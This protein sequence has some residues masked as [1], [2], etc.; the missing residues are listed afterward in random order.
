MN[1]PTRQKHEMKISLEVISDPLVRN[2]L[3]VIFPQSSS[4]RFDQ[5]MLI[6][7]ASDHF[8]SKKITKKNGLHFA[9]FRHTPVSYKKAHLLLQICCSWNG[10]ICFFNGLPKS[11]WKMLL[12]MECYLTAIQCDDPRAHCYTDA[13][14]VG[15]D[16][17]VIASCRLAVSYSLFDDFGR[18]RRIKFAKQ[19]PASLEKQLQAKAV[20]QNCEI[21]P[22]F[23][24]EVIAPKGLN[25]SQPSNKRLW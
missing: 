14:I 24:C 13:G 12:L 4:P 5:A 1:W 19:A 20:D 6:A 7:T 23:K 9:A 11:P 2:M 3:V 17:H 25:S 21:C 16:Q 8:I 15:S 22:L 10:T 18:P